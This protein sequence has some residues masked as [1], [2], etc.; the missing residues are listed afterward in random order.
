MKFYENP[1]IAT[2]AVQSVPLRRPP[3]SNLVVYMSDYWG[4]G[5]SSSFSPCRHQQQHICWLTEV[6]PAQKF[7]GVM[8]NVWFSVNAPSAR[9]FVSMIIHT[10]SG[11]MLLKWAVYLRECF[12]C[13]R[14]TA[15]ERWSSTRCSMPCPGVWPVWLSPSKCLELISRSSPRSLSPSWRIRPSLASLPIRYG[16]SIAPHQ[17]NNVF[18]W[19]KY[20]VA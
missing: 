20:K 11:Y 10:S 15:Q 7:P 3:F 8:D 17:W 1:K 14:M 19:E 5:S 18:L 16:I 9:P 2:Q 12:V 4:M 13:C 6:A